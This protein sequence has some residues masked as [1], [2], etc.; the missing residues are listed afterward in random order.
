GDIVSINDKEIVLAKGGNKDDL[1]KVPLDQVLAV[2]LGGTAGKA[3]EGSKWI[4]VELN[5]GSVFRCTDFLVKKSTAHLTLLGSGQ[6]LEFPLAAVANV[7]NGAQDPATRNAWDDRLSRKRLR[8]IVA[9]IDDS[10]KPPVVNPF[11]CTFGEG[12]EDGKA[13]HAKVIINEKKTPPDTI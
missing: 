8:D 7:L 1:V 3:P 2:D 6:Q 5:D 11:P 9:V 12:S 10:K 4:D 13:I